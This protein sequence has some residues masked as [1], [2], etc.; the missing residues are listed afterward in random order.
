MT[1]EIVPDGKDWTWVL[2]RA[3]PEC[4][5]DATSFDVQDVGEMIRDNAVSWAQVLRGPAQDLRRRLRPDR[6]STLEYGAHVRDVF[7]LYAVRL[8][9]MLHDDDPLFAN[10]DQDETAVA[11]RYR[12]QDPAAVAEAIVA[13]AGEF[14]ATFDFMPD[15]A[16]TRTGRRSDGAEFTVESFARYM[17]HD[18]IH[19]LWD[20]TSA[21]HE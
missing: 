9:L 16:W 20:V 14:A 15:D 5:F 19:H 6:W 11:D 18:P 3:C 4:G 13:E 2:E 8:A 10:W 1:D 12:E 17:I 21:L 7:R